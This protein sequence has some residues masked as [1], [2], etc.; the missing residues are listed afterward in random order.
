MFDI[1][2]PVTNKPVSS[3]S[4]PVVSPL[5]DSIRASLAIFAID[6]ERHRPKH[7]WE[8]PFSITRLMDSPVYASSLQGKPGSERTLA[9]LPGFIDACKKLL[10]LEPQQETYQAL[11]A[12]MA[13]T[14]TALGGISGHEAEISADIARCEETIAANEQ[15]IPLALA[16]GD[17]DGMQE[18]QR[19]NDELA[20]TI[21]AFSAKRSA[22]GE[23][24]SFILLSLSNILERA[25]LAMLDRFRQ[26]RI[27]AMMPAFEKAKRN[28]CTYAA[29]S[30]LMKRQGCKQPLSAMVGR[31]FTLASA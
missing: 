27:Q 17:F 9:A 14:K 2:E 5:L 6:P 28:C 16:A 19:R 12:A 31:V 13:E 23:D 10:A 1:I 30:G 21:K 8:K 26:Q 24:S 4:N 11:K 7:N 3:V 22:L 18:L 15:Q 20:A 25:E 29:R